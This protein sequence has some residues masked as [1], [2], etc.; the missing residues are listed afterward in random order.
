VRQTLDSDIDAWQWGIRFRIDHAAD[1][2]ASRLS[3]DAG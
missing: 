1:H 2:A 3:F